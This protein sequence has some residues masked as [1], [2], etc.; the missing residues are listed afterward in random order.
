V[1]T[2]VRVSDGL[3]NVSAGD[4]VFMLSTVA[5]LARLT[6]EKTKHKMSSVL[7][8]CSLLLYTPEHKKTDHIKFITSQLQERSCMCVCVCVCVYVCTHT[9]ARAHTHTYTHIYK[10]HMRN[11]S[12]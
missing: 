1:V 7:F 9:R 12:I 6:L 10:V 2:G 5:M 8:S 3:Q 11:A 4:E